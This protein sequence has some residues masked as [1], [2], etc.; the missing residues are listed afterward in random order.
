M[1][2]T[3]GNQ[4]N[5]L[6][7]EQCKNKNG[8]ME[9]NQNKTKRKPKTQMHAKHELTKSYKALTSTSYSTSI[10]TVT[11]IFVKKQ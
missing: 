9:K 6:A 10:I 1:D 4:K 8:D 2:R 5:T 11:N 7:S 3:K